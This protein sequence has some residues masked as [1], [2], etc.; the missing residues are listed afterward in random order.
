MKLKEKEDNI[1]INDE[2]IQLTKAFRR[3]KMR[4]ENMHKADILRD[5]ISNLD[6]LLLMKCK[7]VELK[8]KKIDYRRIKKNIRNFQ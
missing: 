2:N 1:N 6:L 7:E 5:K 8:G 4:K 3:K